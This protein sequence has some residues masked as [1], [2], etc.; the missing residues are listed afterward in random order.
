MT[1]YQ[2]RRKPVEL[3]GAGERLTCT[4]EDYFR[5]VCDEYGVKPDE[6]KYVDG[7]LKKGSKERLAVLR[8]VVESCKQEWPSERVA[9]IINKNRTLVNH[10]LYTIYDKEKHLIGM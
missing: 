10:Y 3:F 4:P 8:F 7:Y 9:Q 1:I 6:I 5:Q 2:G